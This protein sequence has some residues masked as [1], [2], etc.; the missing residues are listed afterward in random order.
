MELVGY[1]VLFVIGEKVVG[2]ILFVA[3]VVQ[4][5]QQMVVAV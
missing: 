5:F 3:F 4:V 2:Q 1:F